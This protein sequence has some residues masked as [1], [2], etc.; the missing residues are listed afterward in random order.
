MPGL[1][2]FKII[3]ERKEVK[4]IMNKSVFVK[5]KVSLVI[6]TILLCTSFPGCGKSGGEN[7]GSDNSSIETVSPSGTGITDETLDNTPSAGPAKSPA[8]GG[9]DNTAQTEKPSATPGIKTGKLSVSKEYSD[10]Y[11][12]VKVLGL[13]EYKKIKNKNYTDKAGKGKKFLVLFLSVRNDSIED[14]Y[15]NYNYISARVDGKKTGHTFLV[16]EPKGYP[17]IFTHVKAGESISGFVVWKVP[18]DWHKFEFTYNG[19]KDINNVSLN[20]SFTPE[21]LSNPIIYNPDNL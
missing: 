8:A 1:N 16:N 18:S 9:N 5:G 12:T 7:A 3:Q 21:D 4:S 17:T 10:E 20:A 19:W 6:F 14:D 15:I 11:R 2:Y 13:K